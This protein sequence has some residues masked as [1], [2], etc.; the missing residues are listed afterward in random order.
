[1]MLPAPQQ[2]LLEN[3]CL[4]LCSAQ[5]V[6]DLHGIHKVQQYPQ[7]ETQHKLLASLKGTRLC[8]CKIRKPVDEVES[9]ILWGC[10]PIHHDLSQRP[11]KRPRWCLGLDKPAHVILHLALAELN[12]F[13]LPLGQP[14]EGRQHLRIIHQDVA[15]SDVMVPDCLADLVALKVTNARCHD[16]A[17]VIELHD[18]VYYKQ[19]NHCH[20]SLLVIAT[21][22]R[23][24]AC[25]CEEVHEGFPFHALVECL[26]LSQLR[27]VTFEGLGRVSSLTWRLRGGLHAKTEGLLSIQI[28]PHQPKHRK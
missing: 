26:P 17:Q 19:H 13:L 6:N 3:L 18:V 10:L 25:M 5:C 12:R 27:I 20:S 7:R 23:H 22:L 8:S 15:E 9:H 24:Q 21:I 1:M 2:V 4:R 16:G 11:Q 14:M 28:H